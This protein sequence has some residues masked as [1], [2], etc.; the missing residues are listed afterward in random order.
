MGRL[1]PTPLL[2]QKRRVSGEPIPQRQEMEVQTDPILKTSLKRSSSDKSRVVVKRDS[3]NLRRDPEV[4][5]KEIAAHNFNTSQPK[6][7]RGFK[8]EY[9]AFGESIASQLR[10]VKDQ[11]TIA[12]AKFNIQKILFEA[13]TGVYMPNQRKRNRSLKRIPGGQAL[14][15]RISSEILR[16]DDSQP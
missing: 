9:E 10:S 6:K 3:N 15:W 12:A 14:K 11:Y 7:T 13:E 1:N 16:R 8:D 4:N 5:K 2:I